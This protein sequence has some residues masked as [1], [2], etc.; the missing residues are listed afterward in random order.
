MTSLPQNGATSVLDALLSRNGMTTKMADRDQ[1]RRLPSST[2]SWHCR[3][4]GSAVSLPRYLG[5]TTAGDKTSKAAAGSHHIRSKSTSGVRDVDR[6]AASSRSF[7]AVC[8]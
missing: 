2:G 4:S 7:P 6:S 1:D 8:L 3:S 5:D